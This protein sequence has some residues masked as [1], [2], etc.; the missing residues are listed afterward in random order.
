M[1]KE[2]IDQ[3]INKQPAFEIF[4][5]T[6]TL[7]HSSTELCCTNLE[8]SPVNQN[9][10]RSADNSVCMIGS[11]TYFNDVPNFDLSNDDALQTEVDL[12]GP[13]LVDFY[14][15]DQLHQLQESNEPMQA[16]YD[17]DQE[18]YEILVAGE[19]SLNLHSALSQIISNSFHAFG[20]QQPF[21]SQGEDEN[22]E[23][24]F[25]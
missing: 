13:S 9:E 5:K 15:E 18:S 19:D 6:N 14:K 4:Y 16:I 8:I 23:E 3:I 7:A 12:A 1:T 25:E 22:N 24:I 17:T 11:I 20:N 10:E 2:E 21:I